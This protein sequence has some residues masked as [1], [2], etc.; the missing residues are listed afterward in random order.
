MIREYNRYKKRNKSI[1]I[2]EVI[3]NK[4]PDTQI[5]IVTSDN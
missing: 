4:T 2:K 3:S 1:L 5:V